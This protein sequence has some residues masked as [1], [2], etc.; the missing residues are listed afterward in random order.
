MYCNDPKA[1]TASGTKTDRQQGNDGESLL[2][3]TFSQL[4]EGQRNFE[5]PKSL[6][7]ATTPPQRLPA[8]SKNAVITSLK[9]L[10]SHNNR[11]QARISKLATSLI[12]PSDQHVSCWL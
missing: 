4:R 6:P 5:P 11:A 2:V 12:A 9:L 3:V 8:L 1:E 7:H 10:F